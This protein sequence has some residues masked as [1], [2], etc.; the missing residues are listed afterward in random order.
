MT[1][2]RSTTGVSAQAGRA[3]AAACTAR[4]T[5]SAVQNG[6]RAIV[7]PFDGL[8]T[9]PDRLDR[10]ASQWPPI[11]SFTGAGASRST[12]VA[13]IERFS[14]EGVRTGILTSARPSQV[15]PSL[16]KQPRTVVRT[17]N[18]VREPCRIVNMS[19][20]LILKELSCPASFE[21]A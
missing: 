9:G 20:V 15:G 21:A 18:A 16:G 4:S 11:S 5:S 6:T 17:G 12:W 1:R 14:V 19:N 7:L 8:K 3:L 10:L 2:A 13:V